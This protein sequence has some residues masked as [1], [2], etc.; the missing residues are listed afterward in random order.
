MR[1][2]KRQKIEETVKADLKAAKKKANQ[3]AMKFH[4]AISNIGF[5]G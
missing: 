5:N 1:K 3:D 2:A 4:Q